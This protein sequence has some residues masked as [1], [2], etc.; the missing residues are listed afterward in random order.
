MERRKIIAIAGDARIAENS[1]KYKIAFEVG[2]AL[3]DNGYRIQTGGLGGVMSAACQGAK[4]SLK[5]KEGDIIALVPSFDINEVNEFAD[6]VI[7]TGLDVMR[8]ALV[9]N[10]SAVVAIG[11]GAGTLSEMAFAWT[12]GRL[13]IGISNVDGW[14]SKLAGLKIDSRVRYP[15]IEN[16]MVY[17]ATSGKQVAEILNNNID[18]YYKRHKGIVFEDGI[19]KN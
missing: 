9:A 18:K 6:I 14:S 5:Y 19:R 4:S 16:D 15:E 1:D 13:I 3:V 10:A 7:P 17:P 12:F 8:N 11:G 2:K